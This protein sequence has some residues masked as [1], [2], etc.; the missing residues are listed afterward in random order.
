MKRQ[1]MAWIIA[2]IV[3][4]LL[5][6][7]VAGSTHLPG[8][9]SITGFL[10]SVAPKDN[11]WA[12]AITTSAKIPWNFILLAATFILSWL[13][14][15]WRA[16]ALAAVCFAGL[17]LIGP[18]LQGVIARPRPSPSL[19]RVVGSSSGYSFPSIF[20]LTYA[21]T[22]GYLAI[23]AWNARAGRTRWVVVL[24]CALL[25]FVGGSAR[26]VLGAHWPSDV[27]ASYLIGL[28]WAALLISLSQ[29]HKSGA[30]AR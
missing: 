14:A 10:Q 17:L 24:A 28:I 19:V 18:W 23:L 29:T 26:I 4:A 9:V 15:G 22:A 21:A 11:A 12:E 7:A 13:I 6:V 5:S 30:R 8:D 1:R 25:L 27:M 2:I 20:A 16:A 3:T